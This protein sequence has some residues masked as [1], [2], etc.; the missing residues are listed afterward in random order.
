MN[1]NLIVVMAHTD[2]QIVFDRHF[3]EWRKHPDSDLMV[4]YPEKEPCMP[5]ERL[6][7]GVKLIGEGRAEHHG[8]ESIRRFRW[9]LNLIA[10]WK[11]YDRFTVHEYDSMALWNPGFS[12][13]AD[14]LGA[15][16]YRDDQPGRGFEGTTY[17]HP[18]LCLTRACIERVN[19][20]AAGIPD[21]AERG[22]WDRWIGLVCE[23]GEIQTYDFLTHGLGFSR[24][25]I[26]DGDIPNAVAAVAA[27]AVMLHGV[28]TRNCYEAVKSAYLTT[29]SK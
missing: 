3:G 1:K 20:V 4:F 21:S 27:G 6:R 28:K 7:N 12:T 16:V 5:D 19:T 24:N 29:G 14:D 2:A 8:P 22:F 17:L 11:Q 25:T 9:M 26:N 13:F 10:S 18:P 15:N 23:K